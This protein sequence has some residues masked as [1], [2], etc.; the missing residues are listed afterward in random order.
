MGE[1]PLRITGLE[2]HDLRF[3]TSLQLDGSDAVVSGA[4]LAAIGSFDRAIC[5]EERGGA[6]EGILSSMQ[7]Y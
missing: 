2:T 3:P 7:G 1:P 6:T 4:G 5:W